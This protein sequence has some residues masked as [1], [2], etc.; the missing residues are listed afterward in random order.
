MIG[1][2][3]PEEGPPLAGDVFS[4]KGDRL[5]EGAEADMDGYATFWSGKRKGS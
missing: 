4:S 2:G 3:G 5:A 1:V